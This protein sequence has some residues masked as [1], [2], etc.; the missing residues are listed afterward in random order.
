MASWL[1]SGQ[2][3]WISNASS[4]LKRSLISGFHVPTDRADTIRRMSRKGAIIRLA[5][6]VGPKRETWRRFSNSC[7]EGKLDV[8]SLITHRFPIER[9]QGAYDLITGRVGHPFL[10]VVDYVS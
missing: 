8:K 9:A 6:C 4:T 1:R 5:T 10:G 7:A 2:S 3:A